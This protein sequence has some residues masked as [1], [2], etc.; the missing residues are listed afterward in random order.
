LWQFFQKSVANISIFVINTDYFATFSVK[1][2]R[3]RH[4]GLLHHRLVCHRVDYLL[5]AAALG[6]KRAVFLINVSDLANFL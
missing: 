1:P 4:H 5:G 6:L 2:I 3:Q